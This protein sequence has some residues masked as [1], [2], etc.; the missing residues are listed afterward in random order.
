MVH[1]HHIKGD[2]VQ[3]NKPRTTEE[4][5][6][7]KLADR[8]QSR[9]GKEI[10][11]DVPMAPPVG[12]IKQPSMVEHMRAMVRG[13]L[14]RQAAESAGMETFDEA[15]DFEVE[16]DLVPCSGY[17]NDDQFEPKAV[18]HA[19]AAAE[20]ADAKVAEGKLA[21]SKVASTGVPSPGGGE[22]AGGLVEDGAPASKPAKAA[23]GPT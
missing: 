15:D 17:E 19:R 18:A 12:F 2:V 16:D 11:S 20:K 22:G 13:E 1:D 4:D 10:P 6:A 21:P 3:R 9:D 23:P 5:Y 8:D 14:L 7:L